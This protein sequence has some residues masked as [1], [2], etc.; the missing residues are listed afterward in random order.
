MNDN[1]AKRVDDLM[2]YYTTFSLKECNDG[3]MFIINKNH[4][5]LIDE[6]GDYKTF[7]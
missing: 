5:L 2:K 4:K 6:N 7:I 1:Q 3:V